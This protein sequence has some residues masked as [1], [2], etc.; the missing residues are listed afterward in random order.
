MHTATNAVMAPKPTDI[1]SG[2][3]SYRPRNASID[4]SPTDAAASS[5]GQLRSKRRTPEGIGGRPRRIAGLA[6]EKLSAP[7]GHTLTQSMHFMHP[8]STTMPKRLTSSCTSTLDVH[9]AVQWPH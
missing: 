6:N 1:S 2:G 3:P 4:P 5:S 9:V 7:F 8:G